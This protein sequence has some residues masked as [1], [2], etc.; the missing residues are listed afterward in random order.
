MYIEEQKVADYVKEKIKAPNCPLCGQ[1]NWNI[2]SR[3]FQVAEFNDGSMPLG[4]ETIPVLPLTCLNCGNTYFINAI[5]AGFIAPQ[6]ETEKSS[7]ENA[8]K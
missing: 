1:K 4:N 2:A 5:I 6:K 8:E 3:V 7:E